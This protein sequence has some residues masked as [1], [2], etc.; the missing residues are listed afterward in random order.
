M[1]KCQCHETA[2]KAHGSPNVLSA[3]DVMGGWHNLT[4]TGV[5]TGYPDGLLEGGY[6][7]F[8]N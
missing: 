5:S 6:G 7:R 1:A 8:R 3:V 2:A 4:R